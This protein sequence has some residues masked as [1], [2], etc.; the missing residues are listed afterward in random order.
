VLFR[1]G[2]HHAAVVGGFNTYQG[3]SAVADIAK[4]LGASEFQIRRLTEHIP[5]TTAAHVAEAVSQ[6]QECKEG[7]WGEDPYKTALKMAAFLDGFPRHA[8]MHPCGI[9]LSRDPIA[10]LTPTFTSAKGYPSTHFDMDA[11]ESVGLVKMDILAQG[12]LKSA[13]P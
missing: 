8:K 7:P 9:V 4:V 10:S 6:A 3:R 11:V 1:Y 12:G 5:H 2:P 13:F